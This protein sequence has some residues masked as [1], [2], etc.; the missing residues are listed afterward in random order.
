MRE[1]KLSEEVRAAAAQLAT[2]FN[3]VTDARLIVAMVLASVTVAPNVNLATRNIEVFVEVGV[4]VVV[5]IGIAYTSWRA[6]TSPGVI[7][8]GMILLS[9]T[10]A[11][12]PPRFTPMLTVAVA[13][14]PTVPRA[15][16]CRG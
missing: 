13:A 15:R 7:P 8:P 4:A 14:P 2:T 9:V 16:K 3:C 5:A 10:V 12:D 6:G 11:P 1:L